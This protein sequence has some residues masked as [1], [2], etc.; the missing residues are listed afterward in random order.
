M[1]ADELFEQ[2]NLET[3]IESMARLL[4]SHHRALVEAGFS[5]ANAIVLTG[6]YQVSILAVI[7]KQQTKQRGERW[8]N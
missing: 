3:A 6:S 5:D 7:N 1:N 8:M 4:A 2:A